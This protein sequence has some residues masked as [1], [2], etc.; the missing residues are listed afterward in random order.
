MIILWPAASGLMQKRRLV[1]AC[2]GSFE[3]ASTWARA[4]NFFQTET[5]IVKI[6]LILHM[7]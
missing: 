3:F 4:S 2:M 7:D 1:Y 5:C 6:L